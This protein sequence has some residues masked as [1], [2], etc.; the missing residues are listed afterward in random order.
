MRR[1]FA[2][3]ALA[4]SVIASAP[5]AAAERTVHVSL[6]LF[7][8][9]YEI[10]ERGGRGGFARITAAIHAERARNPNTIVA[11]AGDTFSPSLRSAFDKGKA[12]VALTNMA[13]VDIFVPGNHEFDFG[14][15]VFRERLSELGMPVLA[16]NLS[17]AEG[18]P[19]PGTGDTKVFEFE[20]VKIGVLGL[21]DD[22]S[23][24]RSSPGTLRFA[25]SIP[26]AE[27]QAKDLRAA[28][29]DLIVLVIHAPVQDDIRLLNSGLYDVILSGHDHDLMLFYDGRSVLAEA[30]EEGETL[31]VVDLEI[32][33]G[34]GE[35]RKVSWHPRFRIIDTADVTPDP[36]VAAKVAAFEAELGADLAE[37]I[38][39]V[40]TVLDSRKAAVR[41][42]EAAIGNLITDA[43]RAFAQADVALMNG[44]GIRGDKEYAAGHAL[45]KRDVLTELPFG[46]KLM[47]L[48]LTGADLK[49]AL[50]NGV[51][52]GEKA[53]GRFGQ[54]S[55]A[56]I[57][58][59]RDGVPGSR[60]TAV[61]I[62][63]AP[64]DPTK[65]Y[66]I[67]VNDFVASGKDGYSVLTKGKVLLDANEG[68]LVAT[69]VMD[70]IRAAGTVS[71]RVEGRIRFE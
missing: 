47:V 9:I 15:A 53:E 50:E 58:A 31:V 36:E 27:N 34:E 67:A 66:R 21:T 4:L 52:F 6:A 18:K 10:G 29:A 32:K 7:S 59:R 61:E 46:N 25:P 64:L 54:I 17:D 26:M 8:D 3:L 14:E 1:S 71:P 51:W 22:S 68:P 57:I 56:K 16:A 33:V 69:V 65:L 41:S 40:E 45:T 23:A 48:E 2:W 13:G 35:S 55:G 30:K 24:M 5:T 44:G 11:H 37:E 28:G 63:S 60:L 62:G 70:A 42:G 39:R 12:I 20:G 49:S 38:G 19:L 43:M